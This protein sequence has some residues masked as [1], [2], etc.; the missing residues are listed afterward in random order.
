MSSENVARLALAID[1]DQNG[2]R[3]LL[4]M[5]MQDAALLN[6]MLAV[7]ASHYGR[8]QNNH[9]TVSRKYLR[10]ALKALS[11]RFSH[12][13]LVSKQTTLA[14]MLCLVS[15]E[16]FS[17]SVRWRPHYDAIRGWVLSRGDC[18]DLDPF[19]KTWVCMIDTQCALNLGQPAMKEVQT[20]MDDNVASNG[21]E[22]S[23]DA[24]FGC[25]VELPTLMVRILETNISMKVIGSCKIQCIASQLH[26]ESV[27][28]QLSAEGVLPR[29]KAL[30]EQIRAT[31]MDMS[32]EPAISI[33]C[34][35]TTQSSYLATVCL[36]KEDFR[37][38]MVATAEIFRHAAHI[39]V[40]RTAYGARVPLTGDMRGSL[41]TALKLLT[42]VPDA[43]GPGANLGW[44]LVVIGAELDLKDQ[45]DYIRSRWSRMHLLGMY[46]SKSGQRILEEVWT[47]RDL[48][49]RGKAPAKSWQEI[50]QN[51]GEC[52]ILL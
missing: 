37:R 1:Y 16:V 32:S 51:M 22:H 36:D 26:A 48:V 46:N 18:S 10:E 2:Y 7:G 15:F 44:C 52:Q 3:S 21:R 29:A 14:V 39:Y 47:H 40:Y 17:G 24:L 45:R 5:A 34:S 43:I 41:E 35:K 38:R 20:W 42:V 27:N 6:A 13:E 28:G 31:E 30:Q 23:V 4:S 12:P 49:G 19:L 50:M 11:D 25:S 8:W 33:V 9:E